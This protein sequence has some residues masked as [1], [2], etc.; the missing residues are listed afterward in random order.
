[1]HRECSNHSFDG[2]VVVVHIIISQSRHHN[3]ILSFLMSK[4]F[5]SFCN[6]NRIFCSIHTIQYVI[7][8]VRAQLLCLV[9]VDDDGNFV[10]I[11][12][13]RRDRMQHL[14]NYPIDVRFV[15]RTICYVCALRSPSPW[16]TCY[17]VAVVPNPIYKPHGIASNN[18]NELQCICVLPTFL[19]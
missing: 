15:L 18:L 6:N 7:Y 14:A 3:I 19:Q 1:M 8:Y 2:V 17:C 10:F 5:F 11:I 13:Q 9:V 16:N 12:T 4:Q